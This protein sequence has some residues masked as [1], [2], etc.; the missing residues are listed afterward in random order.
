[1]PLPFVDRSSSSLPVQ[2]VA[3]AE[4]AELAQ[5]AERGAPR[6]AGI[7]G[8]SPVRPA[9]SRCCP[10]A[11]ARRPVQCLCCRPSP[12]SGTSARSPR[13]CRPARGSSATPRRSRRPMPPSRSGSAPGASSATRRR[14]RKAGPKIVWPQGAD[15]ARATA[16]VESMCLARDLITTPSSDMGPAELA[17]AVQALGKTHKA[18]GQRHRGRRS[19]EEE[20]PDGPCRRPRLEPRAAADRSH[21]GQPARSQGDAGRQGRV[22]RHRRP[23]SQARGRHAQHEEGH[24]GRGDHDGRGRHDH[25]HASCRCACGCSS[26]RSRTACRAMPSGRSTWCRRARASA[27][28]SATPTPRAG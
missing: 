18:Q 12:T 8:T 17:A 24:G 11:T 3:P 28:R 13:D 22:L 4:M 25:G 23:R 9:I 7:A 10:D 16:I 14:R 15:K 5:G 2:F 26:R 6:L 20:L 19:P 1:M 21:L 27:S